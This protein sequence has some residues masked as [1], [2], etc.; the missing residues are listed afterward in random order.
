MSLERE[1]MCPVDV[2]MWFHAYFQ[3]S[4][5]RALIGITVDE[6]SRWKQLSQFATKTI[7]YCALRIRRYLCAPHVPMNLYLRRS[8]KTCSALAPGTM[9]SYDPWGTTILTACIQ[10]TGKFYIPARLQ[11]GCTCIPNNLTL[12]FFFISP[13]WLDVMRSKVVN[14][15]QFHFIP[16]NI[17][18]EKEY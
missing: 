16:P 9:Q 14:V 8:V 6:N 17:G 4:C 7:P 5:I 2:E 10:S 1:I 18:D 12:D 3:V 13:I 15:S 11:Y